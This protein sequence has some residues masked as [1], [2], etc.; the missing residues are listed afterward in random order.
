MDEAKHVT[1]ALVWSAVTEDGRRAHIR[2]L[3][4]FHAW[5]VSHPFVTDK[6]MDALIPVYLHHV[7]RERKIC[8][9]TVERIATNIIGALSYARFYAEGVQVDAYAASKPGKTECVMLCVGWIVSWSGKACG[10]V[11]CRLWRR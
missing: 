11:P 4:A 8:W 6:S 3:S 1:P 5:V 7:Q 9:A 2:E 10:V